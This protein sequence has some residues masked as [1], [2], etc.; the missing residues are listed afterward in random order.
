MLGYY[1]KKEINTGIKMFERK[2]KLE[3]QDKPNENNSTSSDIP[4]SKPKSI[5]E[6]AGVKNFLKNFFHF[7]NKMSEIKKE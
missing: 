4:N 6:K 3:N 2:I 7:F 5:S 1:N